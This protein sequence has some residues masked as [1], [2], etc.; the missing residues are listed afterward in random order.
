MTL[1]FTCSPITSQ[2]FLTPL[3]NHE[4]LFYRNT[5]KSKL[6]VNCPVVHVVPWQ[7]PAV[8]V[9]FFLVVVRTTAVVKSIEPTQI[10]I[11]FKNMG[12]FMQSNTCGC[13]RIAIRTLDPFKHNFLL[14]KYVSLSNLF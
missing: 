9:M 10:S 1:L 11:K 2:Y 8:D 6:S 12:H 13:N 3:M 7:H 14:Q 4:C 5:S